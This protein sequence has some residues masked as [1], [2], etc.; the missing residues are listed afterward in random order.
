[1]SK[2]YVTHRQ[3]IGP[4]RMR[5]T[6]HFTRTEMRDAQAQAARET[7]RVLRSREMTVWEGEDCLIIEASL[8]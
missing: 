3:Q 6:I 2:V 4:N 7:A 8:P 1:M 5:Y